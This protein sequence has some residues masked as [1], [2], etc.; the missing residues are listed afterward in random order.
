MT[1][2]QMPDKDPGLRPDPGPGADPE[3]TIRSPKGQAKARGA[4]KTAPEEASEDAPEDA[5]VTPLDPDKN[6]ESGIEVNET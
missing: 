3:I 5:E 2:R 4:D 6:I 1:E